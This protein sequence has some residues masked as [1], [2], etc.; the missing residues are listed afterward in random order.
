MDSE[1]SQ[2]TIFVRSHDFLFFFMEFLNEAGQIISVSRN[3]SYIS[4]H[5]RKDK[6]CLDR[7]SSDG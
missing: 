1:W 5:Y 3:I 4:F 2:K 7:S 6:G